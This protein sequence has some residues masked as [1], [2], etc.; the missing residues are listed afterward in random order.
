MK[1][2]LIVL[3]LVFL[4][5][6]CKEFKINQDN[7][8]VEYSASSR[9]NYKLIVIDKTM[10]SVI[11]KRNIKP[12]VKICNE[13]EWTKLMEV[14]KAVEIENIPNLKAP[15]EARFYDG[16]AIANLKIIY[17]GTTYESQ[18]FDHLSPPKEIEALVKVILSISENIE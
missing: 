11:N 9:G 5:H 14:L 17:N 18:S 4:D 7:I 2:L 12:T 3:S 10:V 16:A 13:D 6:G 8:Y 15:T 1:I